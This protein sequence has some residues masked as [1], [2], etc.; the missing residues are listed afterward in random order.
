MQPS[1]R[2]DYVVFWATSYG[3]SR[4]QLEYLNFYIQ[5]QKLHFPYETV[6]GRFQCIMTARKTY[7]RTGQRCQ[8]PP[9]QADGPARRDKTSPD[10]LH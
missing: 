9:I 8:S 10:C 3:L 5:Q 7:N 4:N 2:P 6:V 1:A